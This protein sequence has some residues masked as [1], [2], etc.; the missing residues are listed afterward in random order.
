MR[1]RVLI[2]G[3]GGYSGRLIASRASALRCDAVLAGRNADRLR[4]LAASLGLPWRAVSLDN[5]AGLDAALADIGVVLHAAG[6]FASTFA[7]MLRACL[8][9]GTHYLDIAGEPTVFQEARCYDAEARAR[10]VMVMPGAGFAVAAS[11]CLAAHVAARAPGARYLRLGFSQPDLASRGSMRTLLGLTHGIVN[12]R[13]NG[14]L[15]SL[16]VGRLAHG[17]DFG[18]GERWSIALSWPDVVTAFETTGIPNIEVYA[19]LDSLSRAAY[20]AAS[21]L[22]APFNEITPR[23]LLQPLTALL[24][25]G[26]SDAQRARSQHVIVAEV[27]DS[28]R[29][30]MRARLTTPNGYSFTSAVATQLIQRVLAEDF[31]AGF[32]TPAGVYGPDLILACEGTRREDL[33]EPWQPATVPASRSGTTSGAGAAR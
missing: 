19:Q 22:A 5:P 33:D 13:R 26:P 28:W 12:V 29:R 8:R 21:W 15:V 17:F 4:P 27:Q 2:Y 7:P 31:R 32:Q 3:A 16:P 18:K 20:Q 1:R 10:G 6:P 30:R 25:E 24:P 23:G 14:A 9:T 11:D